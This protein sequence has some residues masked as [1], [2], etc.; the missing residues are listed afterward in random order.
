MLH[1]E[2]KSKLN[3]RIKANTSVLLISESCLVRPFSNCLT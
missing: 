3:E 2:M 1:K